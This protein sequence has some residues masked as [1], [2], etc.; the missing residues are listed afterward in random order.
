[1]DEVKIVRYISKGN[2][3]RIY[4]VVRNGNHLAMRIVPYVGREG[5]NSKFISHKINSRSNP[6]FIKTRETFLCLVNEIFFEEGVL[7]QTFE[8]VRK[9]DILSSLTEGGRNL[10][11]IFPSVV[12]EGVP[13]L[14][15]FAG[16]TFSETLVYVSLM[17]LADGNLEEIYS[18]V[19]APSHCLNPSGAQIEVTEDLRPKVTEVE[20]SSWVNEYEDWR[21]LSVTIQVA[22]CL[23]R[24]Q[25]ELGLVHN[26][27][28]LANILFKR[29]EVDHT[30][31]Y[32]GY[33]VKTMG[34]EIRVTDFTWSSLYLPDG[35]Y[36]SDILVHLTSSDQLEAT[37]FGWL[38]GGVTT[39]NREID[40]AYVL[41][42]LFRV[43]GSKLI[44]RFLKDKV[45]VNTDNSRPLFFDGFREEV[46]P[47]NYLRYMSKHTPVLVTSV[48]H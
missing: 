25:K 43:S 31:T 21:L 15:E 27:L 4:E 9:S 26:D 20:P 46:T 18:S 19:T 14:I 45:V 34:I 22:L 36:I 38:P 39:M 28:H 42:H 44:Y 40:L 8:L 48:F 41:V 10:F 33:I 17:E 5:P 6:F 3:A 29:C 16:K 30:V 2:D 32:D 13:R 47:S 11:E 37:K 1:M 12:G 23:Q 35:A 24:A 7:K